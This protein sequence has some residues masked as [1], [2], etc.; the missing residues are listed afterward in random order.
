MV[1]IDDEV[2]WFK[3]AILNLIMRCIQYTLSLALSP[4]VGVYVQLS[5]I[6]LHA[7][8]HA[9]IHRYCVYRYDYTFS[10]MISLKTYKLHMAIL[11]KHTL[12]YYSVI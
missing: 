11:Y 1:H 2:L 5:C 4:L 7:C 6:I 9:Y 8:M 10:T 3:V 12:I